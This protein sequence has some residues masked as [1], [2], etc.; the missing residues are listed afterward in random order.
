MQRLLDEPVHHRR[1]AQCAHPALRL[2]NVHP[3]YRLRLIRPRQ[4]FGPYRRPV[5]LQVLFELGHGEL[6]DPRRPLVR[7]HPLIRELQVAAFH[8]G[9]H[10][11]RCRHLRFRPRPG[12][13]VRLG[14]SRSLDRIPSGLLRAR[15]ICPT[16]FRLHRLP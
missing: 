5:S 10:Q 9:F 1:N 12:R 16:S 4:Q 2:G 14:T 15:L 6:I 11:A 7:E 13:H 3:A 8:Y